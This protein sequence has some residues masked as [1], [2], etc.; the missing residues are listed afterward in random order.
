MTGSNETMENESPSIS[1]SDEHVLEFLVSSLSKNQGISEDSQAK[2]RLNDMFG[3]VASPGRDATLQWGRE[4]PQVVLV[5]E[6]WSAKVEAIQT[7]STESSIGTSSYLEK[8]MIT[9]PL[10]PLLLIPH[11]VLETTELAMANERTSTCLALDLLAQ[12][13]VNCRSLSPG[14]LVGESLAESHRVSDET[15]QEG[16]VT[17]ALYKSKQP[18]APNALEALVPRPVDADQSNRILPSTRSSSSKPAGSKKLLADFDSNRTLKALE[19]LCYLFGMPVSC[20]PA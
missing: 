8:R 17:L 15:Y 1:S 20:Y 9:I 11:M 13:H 3:K 4:V 7:G 19:D 18:S 5:P 14:R 6:Y 12:P 10:F 2:S 16:K